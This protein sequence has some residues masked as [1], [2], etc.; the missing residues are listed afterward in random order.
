MSLFND[1]ADCRLIENKDFA[2]LAEL[3][4]SMLEQEE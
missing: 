3:V 1:E 2:P 4:D